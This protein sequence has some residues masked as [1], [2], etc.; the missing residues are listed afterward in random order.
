MESKK[1]NG[2]AT[3]Q[4]FLGTVELVIGWFFGVMFFICLCMAGEIDEAR[5]AYIVTMLIMVALNAF[6]IFRGNGRRKMVKNFRRYVAAISNAHDGD[7]NNLAAALN[8]STDQVKKNVT[9]MIDKK[10]FKNAS[11]DASTNSIVIAGITDFAAGMAQPA[12][13]ASQASANAT[14]NAMTTVTCPGCGATQ[15]VPVGGSKECDF[16]GH[17]LNG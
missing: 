10:L 8:E 15:Q 4:M 13:A 14:T 17:I 1:K 11:Y 7:L 2:A 16:C 5:G 12:A 6:L 9:S 3:W